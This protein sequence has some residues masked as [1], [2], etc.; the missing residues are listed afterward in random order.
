MA[1]LRITLGIKGRRCGESHGR[2]KISD[3]EVDLIHQL[4]EAGM[5]STTIAAKFGLVRSHVWRI[6]RGLR[7]GVIPEDIK[8]VEPPPPSR[9]RRLP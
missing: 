3:H 9:R 4:A 6:I 5:P 8:T 7:R 2:A 1:K